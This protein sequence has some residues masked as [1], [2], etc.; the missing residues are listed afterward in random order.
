MAKH[1]LNP[2]LLID[3][4]GVKNSKTDY[5]CSVCKKTADMARVQQ[6]IWYYKIK[7]AEKDLIYLEKNKI[8]FI[9]ASKVIYICH[10]D[11]LKLSAADAK[12]Y[13]EIGLPYFL[14][15]ISKKGGIFSF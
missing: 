14:S 2:S 9:K 4:T 13:I 8:G 3:E 1:V 11:Y 15:L 7:A 10:D 6:E 5:I 12:D